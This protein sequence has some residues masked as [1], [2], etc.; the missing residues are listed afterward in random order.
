[1]TNENKETEARNGPFK[2]QILNVIY[3]YIR[4]VPAMSLGMSPVSSNL[5]VLTAFIARNRESSAH[6][7][8]LG[9]WLREWVPTFLP[10][11]LMHPT[12]LANLQFLSIEAK[13]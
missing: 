2:E 6:C 12:I 11:Y 8:S 7:E 1:M 13:R 3:L 10:T 9:E 4:F 5:N